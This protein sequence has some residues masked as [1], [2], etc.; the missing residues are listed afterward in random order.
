MEFGIF[1]WPEGLD[2]LRFGNKGSTHGLQCVDGL[3]DSHYGDG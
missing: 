2:D 1:D 3:R